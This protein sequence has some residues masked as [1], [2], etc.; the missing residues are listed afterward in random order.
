MASEP[1]EG[2]HTQ[3]LTLDLV[4]KR[5]QD[6]RAL[7]T[8]SADVELSDLDWL[9]RERAAVVS[10]FNPDDLAPAATAPPE[11]QQAY[12]RLLTDSVV[13]DVPGGE[14]HFRLPDALR[15]QALD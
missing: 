14:R 13:V 5:L 3:Y 12:R 11:E 6:S 10:V 9:Y 15:K 2:Q 4:K 1:P 7:V 8:T